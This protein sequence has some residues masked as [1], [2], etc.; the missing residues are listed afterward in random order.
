MKNSHCDSLYVAISSPA[1]WSKAEGTCYLASVS[2][3]GGG[4][5]YGYMLAE[6]VDV[7]ID[8]LQQ[9]YLYVM[10]ELLTN[11]KLVYRQ[12][13]QLIFHCKYR[14]NCLNS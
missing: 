2:P 3:W 1:R 14:N 8:L 5:Q 6:T 10:K 12:F 13:Q 9:L 4:E 7:N 11:F